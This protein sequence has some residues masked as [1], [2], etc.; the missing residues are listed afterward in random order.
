MVGVKV[1]LSRGQLLKNI[2]HLDQLDK[3]AIRLSR[4]CHK[5]ILIRVFQTL[6]EFMCVIRT[7]IVQEV[8]SIYTSALTFKLTHYPKL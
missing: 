3:M 1:I 7:R 8:T 2:E 6:P 5:E 4:G